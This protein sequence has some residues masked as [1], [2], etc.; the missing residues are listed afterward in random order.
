MEHSEHV[1]ST[2]NFSL[3]AS[4]VR[5]F[6]YSCAYIVGLWPKRQQRSAQNETDTDRSERHDVN[7]SE[8]SRYSKRSKRNGRNVGRLLLVDDVDDVCTSYVVH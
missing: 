3:A 2:M 8:M 4:A 6:S 1:P 7:P 5:N